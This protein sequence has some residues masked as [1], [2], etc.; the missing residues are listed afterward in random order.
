VSVYLKPCTGCPLRN[1]C[2]QR[3]EFRKRV[4]GLGLRSATFNCERLAKAI[5]AGTRILV[6]HPIRVETGG[7]Y[8][9]PEYRIIRA[10]FSATITNSDRDKFSC[11]IDRDALVEAIDDQG[12]EDSEKV[13]TYRFRKKMLAR[14][15]VRFLDEPKRHICGCGNPVLPSGECD[16]R[17]NEDCWAAG[18]QNGK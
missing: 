1:G 13:D 15:V 16:K 14:R 12:G 17:S 7:S 10:D 18:G 2:E 6:S 8:E 5:Q 4:S 11:V 9:G 3:D